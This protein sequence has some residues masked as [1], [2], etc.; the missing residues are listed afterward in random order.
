MNMENV[1]ETQEYQ[2]LQQ[3]YTQ[4]YQQAQ[5]LSNE[6][7]QLKQDKIAERFE[8]I[9]R[10]LEHKDSYTDKTLKLAEWHIQQMLAKPKAEK[11]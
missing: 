7:T 8:L 10:V 11:E 5:Q 6:L 1:K 9:M 3:A 4:L 2:E